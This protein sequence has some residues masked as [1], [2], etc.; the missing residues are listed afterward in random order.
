MRCRN[1]LLHLINWRARVS[2]V[3]ELAPDMHNT[4]TVDV[5]DEE[6]VFYDCDDAE[7]VVGS[8]GDAGPSH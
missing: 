5:D 8:Q 6:V 7:D 1:A 3:N 4:D 2:Q